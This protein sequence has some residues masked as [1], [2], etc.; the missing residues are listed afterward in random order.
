MNEQPDRR[1][2][3]DQHFAKLGITRDHSILMIELQ[4][5]G[6]CVKIKST[7]KTEEFESVLLLLLDDPTDIENIQMIKDI[8]KL[9]VI[10]N[11]V[12]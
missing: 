9:F 6:R 2:K 3:Y 5:A 1:D 4:H 8:V 7:I 12:E 10:Y 11:L